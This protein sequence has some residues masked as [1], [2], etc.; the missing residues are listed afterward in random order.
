MCSGLANVLVR[1][2]SMLNAAKPANEQKPEYRRCEF[3]YIVPLFV[4][5]AL[6]DM[7]GYALAPL[8]LLAPTS[9]STIV[10]NCVAARIVL[11]EIMSYADIFGSS[12]IFVG[13]IV[14]TVFGSKESEEYTVQELL[15]LYKRDTFVVFMSVQLPLLAICGVVALIIYPRVLDVTLL[16]YKS[17]RDREKAAREAEAAAKEESEEPESPEAEKVEGEEGD[18]AVTIGSES[19]IVAPVARSR[20]QQIQFSI[21]AVTF[22]IVTSGCCCWSNILLKSCVEMTVKSISGDNQAGKWQ[23]WVFWFALGGATLCQVILMLRMMEPFEATF[24]IPM[25]QSILIIVLIVSGGLYFN[26]FA[27]FTTLE[28]IMFPLGCMLCVLGI[29]VIACQNKQADQSLQ[30]NNSVGVDGDA[31]TI[32]A[33]SEVELEANPVSAKI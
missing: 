16:C 15:D 30:E 22:V 6:L 8:S 14:C 24:I 31:A 1:R 4:A 26:E 11:K 29:L 2:S 20:S 18:A 21:W 10:V 9:A 7:A 17:T 32:H 28:F 13:A 19:A 3:L 27:K 23:Y 5:N 33:G 25:Y 12:V